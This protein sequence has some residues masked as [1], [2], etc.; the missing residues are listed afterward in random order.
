[1][2]RIEE[3]Y[4]LFEKQIHVDEQRQPGLKRFTYK[5]VIPNTQIIKG[6]IHFVG[7]SFSDCPEIL[8]IANY[9]S[10]VTDKGMLMYNYITTTNKSI[11]IETK[12]TYA[13][14]YPDTTIVKRDILHDSHRIITILYDVN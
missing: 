8:Y 5:L 11:P 3:V 10:I 2:V 4:E 12:V 14:G 6:T 7:S 1:M 9:V 13:A